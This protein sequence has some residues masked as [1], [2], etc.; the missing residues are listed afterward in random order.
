[1]QRRLL[2]ELQAEARRGIPTSR[3]L[4]GIS[5]GRH[6][7]ESRYPT[8]VSP[9]SPATPRGA[10]SLE[11]AARRSLGSD[12]DPLKDQKS[13]AIDPTFAP[14]NVRPPCPFLGSRAEPGIVAIWVE[15][16]P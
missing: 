3:S 4:S 13:L 9:P 5:V 11:Q 8:P 1:M 2:E 10:G 14:P 7:S 16:R 6:S 12:F 15:L